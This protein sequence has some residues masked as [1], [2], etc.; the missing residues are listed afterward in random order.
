[1]EINVTNSEEYDLKKNDIIRTTL[2]LANITQIIIQ[3]RDIFN[4]IE[5]SN[6]ITVNLVYCAYSLMV[7]AFIALSFKYRECKNL[8]LIPA[9]L[10]SFKSNF[11]I[12][13]FESTKN[14]MDRIDWDELVNN[15]LKISETYFTLILLF[16]EPELKSKWLSILIHIPLKVFSVQYS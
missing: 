10:L 1:M 9:V 13:D 16:F 2:V 7:T 4:P 12:F 6:Q 15:N 8:V 5:N 3:M 14:H 11:R